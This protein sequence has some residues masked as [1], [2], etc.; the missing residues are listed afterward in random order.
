MTAPVAKAAAKPVAQKVA[1]TTAKNHAQKTAESMVSPVTRGEATGGKPSVE[2][3]TKPGHVA[4]RGNRKDV[5]PVERARFKFSPPLRPAKS[6]VRYRQ[7]LALEVVVGSI[8]IC[9]AKPNS[10]RE[11]T[12]AVGGVMKQEAAFLMVMF[13]LSCITVIGPSA[14]RVSAALG[15]LVV[16]TLAMKNITFGSSGSNLQDWTKNAFTA[17]S[18]TNSVD[19]N[20][21]NNVHDIVNNV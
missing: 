2:K 5:G 17:A 13:V 7:I 21:P 8:I 15:G 12:A 20:N 14:A 3:S 18:A 4:R 19:P 6:V 1:S 9:V 16:T 11:A 10:E